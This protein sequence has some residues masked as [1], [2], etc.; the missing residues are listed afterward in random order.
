MFRKTIELPLEMIELEEDNYH[1]MLKSRLSDGED[2]WWIV[3]TGASKTVFDRNQEHYFTLVE[4]QS[5]QQYQSAGINE[6]MVDTKVGNI[7]KIQFGPL[8]IKNLKVALIDLKHVNDIYQ[9]Y[10][11]KRVAGLLGSDVLAVYGCRI[12]YLNKSIS[13]QTKPIQK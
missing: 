9:K 8:K 4:S 3:D 12:D 11:D 13:F 7:T 2:A 1:L 5:K 6:G 10:H